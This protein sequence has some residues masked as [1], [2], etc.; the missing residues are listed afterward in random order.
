[1]SLK[2]VYFVI[3]NIHLWQKNC[4]KKINKSVEF[5]WHRVASF[6]ITPEQYCIG[7]SIFF[8][9]TSNL[10][11]NLFRHVDGPLLEKVTK[12]LEEKDELNII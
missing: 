8:I 1:M 11:H 5:E 10:K 9:S 7:T 6:C 12:I 2:I 4:I 3:K